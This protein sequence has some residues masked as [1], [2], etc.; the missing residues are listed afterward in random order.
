M[1]ITNLTISYIIQID[2]LS[3]WTKQS[4]EFYCR[5][6]ERINNFASTM[7]DMV[8]YSLIIEPGTI[9]PHLSVGF[10]EIQHARIQG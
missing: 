5:M 8:K 4:S 2:P 1:I 6:L 9:T 10:P 3:N 7:A